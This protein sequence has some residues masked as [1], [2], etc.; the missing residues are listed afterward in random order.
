MRGGSTWRFDCNNEQLCN[1]LQKLNSI[2]VLLFLQ[3]NFKFKNK[4][5]HA[6]L[7]QLNIIP[8]IHLYREV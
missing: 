3:N 2:I 4:L 1:I 6:I 5:K 7:G 8:I